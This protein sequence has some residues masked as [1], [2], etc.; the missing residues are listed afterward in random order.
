MSPDFRRHPVARFLLPLVKHHD[1]EAVEVYCYSSVTAP[2]DVT[3]QFKQLD[4]RFIEVA[5]LND[6]E[7]AERIRADR[8]DILLDLTQHMPGCRLGVFARKPAPVQA[9]W[10]GYIGT[11]GL[12]AMDYRLTDGWIDPPGEFDGE[13][14]E[15]PIRLAHSYWC[16]EPYIEEIEVA[17]LP[18]VANGFVTFGC[19]NGFLKVTEPA[20]QCWAELLAALP[21]ARMEIHSPPADHRK[22][23]LAIFSRA[24]VEAERINFVEN[25]PVVEYLQGYHRVDIALDPFPYGGGTT[26]CDAA[27]MGVPTVTLRGRTG[28]GRGGVSILSN[29]GLPDWIAGDI[30]E[31]KSIATRMAG[32]LAR[33]NEL[34]RNLRQRMRNSPLM[35]AKSFSSDFEAALR[36]MWVSWAVQ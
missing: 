30:E 16:Y 36:G 21:D 9:A 2:D 31:Y 3:D 11:T 8:I 35:D 20:L 28:V 32:D 18:A 6:A 27:W 4:V 33:L 26:T 13:Y 7:L 19:F 1:R 10:L 22:K 29:L 34:R 14:S 5:G 23:V 12:K 17:P 25:K 24:G 15:K